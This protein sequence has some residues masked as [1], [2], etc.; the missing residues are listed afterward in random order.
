MEFGGEDF[1]KE[2]Q[3]QLDELCDKYESTVKEIDELH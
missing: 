2:A 3:K 1:A